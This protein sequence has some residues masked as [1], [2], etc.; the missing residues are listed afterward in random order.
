MGVNESEGGARDGFGWGAVL[1]IIEE[2]LIV[3]GYVDGNGSVD[4]VWDYAVRVWQGDGHRIAA[5]HHLTKHALYKDDKE[6]KAL[7][8]TVGKLTSSGT[9][10]LIAAD[11]NVSFVP[12]ATVPVFVTARVGFA[13]KRDVGIVRKYRC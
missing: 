6:T 8:G 3:R 9:E 5:E 4:A 7:K 2:S 1:D 12:G 13:S 11:E 10:P